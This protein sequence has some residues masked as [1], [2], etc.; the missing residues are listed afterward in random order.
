MHRTAIKPA[1]GMKARRSFPG[2]A[3]SARE[4]REW[5]VTTLNNWNMDIPD[6]LTL[7]VSELATNAITHTLSGAPGGQFTVR[8][9]IKTPQHVYV[10]VRDAGP[11]QGRTPTRRTP[12]LDASHGRGLALVNLC[13]SRWGTLTAGTGVWAEVPIR[14]DALHDLYAI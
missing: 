9:E 12:R 10:A 2:S 13:S 3:A 6:P 5:A 4:A 8:L 1:Q 14:Q 11:K 7:V